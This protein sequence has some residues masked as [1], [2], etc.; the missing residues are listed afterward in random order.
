[1]CYWLTDECSYSS[2]IFAIVNDYS[3]R[4][5]I[6]VSSYSAALAYGVRPFALLV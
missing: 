2:K 6:F 5:G 1:M 3:K 4:D